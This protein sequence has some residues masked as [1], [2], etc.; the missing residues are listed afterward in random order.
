MNVWL[1]LIMNMEKIHMNK[2][3]WKSGKYSLNVNS[4]IW[5]K[6][7]LDIIYLIKQTKMQKLCEKLSA[8]HDSAA[9]RSTFHSSNFTLDQCGG[10]LARSSLG[11]CFRSL[12]F[13]H[14]S[15]KSTPQH[16]SQVQVWTQWLQGAQ[17][18]LIKLAKHLLYRGTMGFHRTVSVFWLSFC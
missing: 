4:N 14:S 13:M 3:V 15:L 18:K 1:G 8:P 11:H 7:C 12:K 2:L 10:V 16:F 6:T 9:C 17:I 5:H